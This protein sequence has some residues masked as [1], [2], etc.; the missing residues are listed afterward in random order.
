GV[1]CSL[2]APQRHAG[3]RLHGQQA[4]ERPTIL[5]EQ[6]EIAKVGRQRLARIENVLDECLVRTAADSR[7]LRAHALAVALHLMTG[8]TVFY[9][10]AAASLGVAL[11]AF[12]FQLSYSVSVASDHPST[13]PR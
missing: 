6:H 1:L 9:K 4:G 11:L 13:I 8:Q 5:G 7:Q 12:L 10:Q 3:C 2:G